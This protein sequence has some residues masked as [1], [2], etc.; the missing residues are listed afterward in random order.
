MPPDRDACREQVPALL[1]C[2]DVALL[3]QL[4]RIRGIMNKFGDT[5]A[6]LWV[7]ERGRRRKHGRRR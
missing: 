1:E 6:S 3:R 5:D 4:K 2:V 7:T